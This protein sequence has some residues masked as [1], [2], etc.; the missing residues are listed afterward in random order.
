MPN[1]NLMKEFKHLIDKELKE[2][3][4]NDFESALSWW[5][6]TRKLT[7]EIRRIRDIIERAFIHLQ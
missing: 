1:E 6:T 2:N 3:P 5:K 7:K 4:I